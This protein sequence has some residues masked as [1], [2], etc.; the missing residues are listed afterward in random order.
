MRAVGF[1]KDSITRNTYAAIAAGACRH[2]CLSWDFGMPELPPR[3]RIQGIA[4]I[5]S[6]D[7]HDSIDHYRR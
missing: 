1:Q 3:S 5:R 2:A 4:L 6:R 7:I